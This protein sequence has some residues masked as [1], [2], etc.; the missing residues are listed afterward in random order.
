MI[1]ESTE[2]IAF[3]ATFDK[4]PPLA[5]AP[6]IH[7]KIPDPPEAPASNSPPASEAV[8]TEVCPCGIPLLGGIA[9]LYSQKNL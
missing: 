2:F 4:I 7:P 1:I 9:G 6:F 8:A 5:T 3:S